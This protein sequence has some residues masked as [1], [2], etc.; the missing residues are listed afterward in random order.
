MKTLI[1]YSSKCLVLVAV[2]LSSAAGLKAQSNEGLKQYRVTAYKNGNNNIQS[3]SNIANVAPMA[4]IF[5]PTA[6]TPNEDGINEKFGVVGQGLGVFNM[7]IYNA[8][9][10]KIFECNKPEDG[11]DGTFKGKVAPVGTY[12]YV[13]TARSLKG[14]NIYRNGDFALV[15]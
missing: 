12:L 13:V 14:D 5:I 4:T 9:G 15:K 1:T 6:F 3:A 11:W 7:K 10:E 8:W 2:V